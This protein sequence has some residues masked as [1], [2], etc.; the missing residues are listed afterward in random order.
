MILFN[1]LIK[2]LLLQ[3]CNECMND[4]SPCADLLN[5][6]SVI[7]KL[8]P[9]ISLQFVEGDAEKLPFPD[10]S[11]DAYTIAFGLRNVTQIDVAIQEAHRVLRKGGRFMCLEFSQV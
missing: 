9:S 11:F 2:S 6:A 8:A 3:V 7:A 4:Q 5:A 10:Q 1:Q